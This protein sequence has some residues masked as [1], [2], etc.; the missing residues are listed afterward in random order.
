[1]SS[2]PRMRLPRRSVSPRT[3]AA[4][5]DDAA[6]DHVARRLV[7]VGG[8]AADDRVVLGVAGR[9]GL[10]VEEP[11][12]ERVEREVDRVDRLE[13]HERVAGDRVEVVVGVQPLHRLRR[14]DDGRH[15]L[16]E[17]ERQRLD[18]L[19]VAA[20]DTR[21]HRRQLGQR[22]R[23][24]LEPH[25]LAALAG[26][27]E[28]ELVLLRDDLFGQAGDGLS[29]GG[30]RGLFGVTPATLQEFEGHGSSGRERTGRTDRSSAPRAPAA[31]DPR[32]R[33]AVRCS[34]IVRAGRAA[35]RPGPP[36]RLRL[37]WPRPR[38]RAAPS[39]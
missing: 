25:A 16:R 28:L 6:D 7:P 26:V 1:M 15:R 24:G 20:G 11:A 30:L 27:V 38:W 29:L 39:K 8:D 37:P 19:D 4:P 33:V 21:Q 9:I 22:A 18:D 14:A 5:A 3:P 31:S 23:A 36:A 32:T 35:G 34:V 12:R 17:L 13:D 2:P 10:A